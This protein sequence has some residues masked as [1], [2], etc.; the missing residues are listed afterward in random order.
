MA[1]KRCEHGKQLKSCKLCKG[2]QICEHNRV[3]SQC[4]DCGGGSVCPHGKQKSICVECHGSQI[5]IHSKRKSRCKECGGGALCEHGKERS[6]SA[7]ALVNPRDILKF[8]CPML[9][10]WRSQLPANYISWI[11]ITTLQSRI[12]SELAWLSNI[13]KYYFVLDSALVGKTRINHRNKDCL[14]TTFILVPTNPLV[15]IR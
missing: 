1:H 8:S 15:E 11:S 13:L 7:S 2:S 5:C 9:S 14:F 10:T 6:I 3:R 4:R 12:Y